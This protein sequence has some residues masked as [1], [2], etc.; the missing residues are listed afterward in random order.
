MEN[1]KRAD[2][3]IA[4]ASEYLERATRAISEN[5]FVE[6]E[7]MQEIAA[8]YQNEAFWTLTGEYIG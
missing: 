2:Y 1:I 8:S 7:K 5:K 6:A 3:L 4:M